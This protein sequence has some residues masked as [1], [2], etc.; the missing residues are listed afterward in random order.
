MKRYLILCL[1]LSIAILSGCDGS[2]PGVNGPTENQVS[3]LDEK[4]EHKTLKIV[5]GAKSGNLILA[6]AENSFIYAL[7]ANKVDILIDG[8]KV[9]LK[10]LEDGMP[11]DVYCNGEFINIRHEADVPVDI[12]A[13]CNTINGHT[14]GTERN[15]GGTCYDLSGLYL[16]VLEDLWEVDAGLNGGIKYISIDLSEAPGE[17]TEGEKSAIS[18]IFAKAHNTQCLQLSFEELREQGYIEKDELYW[19]D[20]LLFSITDSMKAEEKYNG[21]RVIKFDAQKWR[22]G[23]GAY[24][25]GD[26]S[27]SWSQKGTWSDYNIG[28][29]AI[30]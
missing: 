6:G 12:T 28:S 11:I 18:Y 5:D 7:D 23:T 29:Q 15:P 22:S 14:I 8:K 13:L 16:K 9:E 26:C 1:I 4:Y 17:L 30:S 21:L 19:E 27:A 2:K 20:G 10:D 3:Y 25:F 24:Y